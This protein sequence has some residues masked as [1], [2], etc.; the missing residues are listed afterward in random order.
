[1]IIIWCSCCV[2][3]HFTWFN[4]IVTFFNLISDLMEE[5]QHH[6]KTGGNNHSQPESISLLK[7][8]DKKSVTCTQC[9]KIFSNKHSL[10]A[11]MRIHTGEKPF[12]CDQCGKSFTQR[13]NLKNHMFIHTGEK[14]HECDQCG[15]TFWGLQTWRITWKF[16]RRRNH[17]HVLYVERVFHICKI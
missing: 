15:K 5:K 4:Y 8:R 7:R 17:I 3:F 2:C 13:G 1:M 16:I 11:H 6:V 9:G 10:E 12:T 14:P